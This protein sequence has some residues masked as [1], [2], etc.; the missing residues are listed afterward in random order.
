MSY[1]AA[2]IGCGK[3]GSE[4]A[5]DP[6][7]TGIRTHAQAYAASA[8]TALV[9]VCDLDAQRARA[10]AQRWG[11]AAWYSDARRLLAEQEP[12]LVSICTPDATH[13]EVARAAL[14][15]ASVRAILLEKPLALTLEEGQ[16]LVALAHQ[17]GVILAVNYSRR[18]ARSHQRLRDSVRFGGLGSLQ[19]VNGFYTK[20]TLHNGTHWF[21]LV[22]L[23]AGE[24]RT[25]AGFD[26][27]H[28]PGPDPTLDARLEFYTGATGYLQA[29]DAGAFTL[30]ECDLVGTRGRVRLI[31]SGQTFETYAVVDSPRH[32]GY[33]LLA[34]APGLKGGMDDA[35]SQAIADLVG[36][37][38]E[39]RPPLCSGQDALA[40]LRMALAVRESAATGKRIVL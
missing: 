25:I 38:K 24:V 10:C 32:S 22:R 26:S 8:D 12:E 7:V 18:Y 27:L 6:R 15:T 39:G 9:A 36:A 3:I 34:P 40:A 16:E 20:G 35:M 37:V 17:R 29:C 11:A 19:T 1:R 21:D 4:W 2:L 5:D 13:A 23:L 31:E 28:E 33:R 14:A 30:F